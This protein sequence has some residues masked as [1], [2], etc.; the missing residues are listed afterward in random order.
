MSKADKI[1][2]IL[3][4]SNAQIANHL[5]VTET[6]VRT[7][8]QRTSSNGFPK[9]AP[10]ELGW[11]KSPALR[12]WA[13]AYHRRYRANPVKNAAINA[14]RRARRVERREAEAAHGQ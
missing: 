7:V 5:G 6:Y 4:L 9:D 3:H 8:R 10:G 14:R 2:A 1:R 11:R 13:V 12:A